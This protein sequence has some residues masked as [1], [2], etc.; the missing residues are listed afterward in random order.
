MNYFLWRFI[1]SNMAKIH[2]VVVAAK[3]A[4]YYI[5]DL[6]NTGNCKHVRNNYLNPTRL[7]YS[8]ITTHDRH[9]QYYQL[10]NETNLNVLLEQLQFHQPILI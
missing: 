9:Y 10:Y 2:E 5:G 6:E 3:M 7:T 1:S 8:P 4:G